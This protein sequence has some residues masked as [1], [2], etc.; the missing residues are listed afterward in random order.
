MA[1]FDKGGTA[2]TPFG[3]NEF[4]RSPKNKLVNSYTVAKASVT[5]QTID[6][7]SGQ[8]ILPKGM[9]M[10]KITSGGDAGKIGPYQ[11]G[12]LANEVQT[13]TITGTP[14]GGTFRPAFRGVATA[15]IA[16][17]AAASAVQTALLDL[18]NVGPTDLAV[19]GG[20]GPGTPFTVTYG[21]NLAGQNVDALTLDTNSLTGGSTPTVVIATTTQGG[22]TTGAA[23]DGRQDPL[24][25]VGINHTFL[26]W[27]LM[28]HDQEVGI[29]YGCV[30][31]QAWCYEYDASGAPVA[32]SNATAGAMASAGRKDLRI[33]FQ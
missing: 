32:L 6:G 4:L 23:T 27:Q 26:P 8:K 1:H 22:P 14:T 7:V 28:E 33:T 9:V 21:G 20:P 29:V 11:G 30:A 13:V 18:P 24:N 3:N 10:A 5:A 12:T 25:I 15:P 16:F 17:N 19:T 31:V 2:L